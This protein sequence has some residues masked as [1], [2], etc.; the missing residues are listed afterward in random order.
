MNRSLRQT[1]VWQV[2]TE[3]VRPDFWAPWS[4][5]WA[6]IHFMYLHRLKARRFWRFT[7]VFGSVSSHQVRQNG[8]FGL[9]SGGQQP[10]KKEG[11][12]SNF[13]SVDSRSYHLGC[14]DEVRGFQRFRISQGWLWHG[15]FCEE[16][17]RCTIAWQNWFVFGQTALRMHK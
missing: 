11:L 6:L 5:C 15:D 7:F 12:D 17:Q 8:V 1:V 4:P 13:S 2:R 9:G 14:I 3:P 16:G 10:L